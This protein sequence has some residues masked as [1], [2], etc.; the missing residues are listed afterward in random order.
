MPEAMAPAAK[1]SPRSVVDM[2]RGEGITKREGARNGSARPLKGGFGRRLQ[3]KRQ[4][5][6]DHSGDERQLRDA[7]RKTG[8]AAKTE[9]GRDERDNSQDDKD[10]KE[11]TS[12]ESR[13]WGEG[14]SNTLS[15]LAGCR[16]PPHK[17]F[18]PSHASV[19]AAAVWSARS[20]TRRW[21]RTARWASTV[22]IPNV[23]T[24]S[25]SAAPAASSGSLWRHCSASAAT[26]GS[27][28]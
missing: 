17:G 27:C 3:D 1:A 20:R 19:I 16:L 18:P 11:L 28:A 2:G 25:P 9:Q 14:I 4:N 26:P 24:A 21:V 12:H 8:D 15:S 10:F 13:G 6:Q 5:K 7:R 22:R 23:W